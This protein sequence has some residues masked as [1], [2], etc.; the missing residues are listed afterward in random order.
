MLVVCRTL[1]PW[2]RSTRYVFYGDNGPWPVVNGIIIHYYTLLF[3]Y[4]LSPSQ[5]YDMNTISK[6][7]EL[8]GA[9]VLGAAAAPS[10]VLGMN[11]EVNHFYPH[12]TTGPH[13][14]IIIECCLR[15][16]FFNP[17][18]RYDCERPHCI[19]NLAPFTSI[20]SYRLII[21]LIKDKLLAL[22]RLLFGVWRK[23]QEKACFCHTSSL[24]MTWWITVWSRGEV[25]K[26]IFQQYSANVENIFCCNTKGV[27][28][29][30]WCH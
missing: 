4:L 28:F 18:P 8:P 26:W 12:R 30:S 14:N 9:F 16:P 21:G 29:D 1:S 27:V 24:W 10:R 22:V 23:T 7:L 6:E 15:V 17:F 25:K 13:L 3:I 20:C 19:Q 11:A 2:F 5:E